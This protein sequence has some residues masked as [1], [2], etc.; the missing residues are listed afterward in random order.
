VIEHA[1][2]AAQGADKDGRSHRQ[3]HLRTK[4]FLSVLEKVKSEFQTFLGIEK[5]EQII[6]LKKS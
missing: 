1:A 5:S 4:V 6:L 3:E 2:R